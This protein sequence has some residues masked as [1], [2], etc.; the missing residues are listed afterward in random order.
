MW[1]QL[2]LCFFDM[3]FAILLD[4]TKSSPKIIENVSGPPAFERASLIRYLTSTPPS[5]VSSITYTA[6]R[7]N[8]QT[9]ACLLSG[10]RWVFSPQDARKTTVLWPLN[11][12]F[13]NW[14]D[15]TTVS[16]TSLVGL[17]TESCST[18]PRRTGTSP[19]WTLCGPRRLS[20]MHLKQNSSISPTDLEPGTIYL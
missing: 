14:A 1:Y 5:T 7:M 17:G 16:R 10:S 9:I 15:V 8:F 12:L 19:G 20:R 11:S 6:R 3:W 13:V 2:D 18:P 4:F